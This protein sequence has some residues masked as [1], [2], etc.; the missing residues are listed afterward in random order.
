MSNYYKPTGNPMFICPQCKTPLWEWI[1][2]DRIRILGVNAQDYEVGFTY[3]KL[4]CKKCGKNITRESEIAENL[5]DISKDIM[6]GVGMKS[7]IRGNELNPFI[8]LNS[9]DRKK[10]YEKLSKKQKEILDFL[11]KESFMG[12][13][14]REEVI[15][16]ITIDTNLSIEKVKKHI[17]FIKKEAKKIKPDFLGYDMTIKVE[18]EGTIVDFDV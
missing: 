15:E 10:L 6:R 17:E 9:V 13:Q 8:R 4:A 3:I 1:D 2:G 14:H 16:K 5:M 7:T 12:F 11:L 18:P